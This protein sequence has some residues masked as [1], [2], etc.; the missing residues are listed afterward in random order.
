MRKNIAI[1]AVAVAAVL[2]VS[3]VAVYILTNSNNDKYANI[4]MVS[5]PVYG[6]A[7]EDYTINQADVDMINDLISDETKWE[8]HPY[9]D[10]DGDGK[11][12]SDDAEIVKKLINGESTKVRFIDQYFYETGNKHLVE[13]D[14]PLSNV[15]TIN[16]DMAQLTFVFDGGTVEEWNAIEKTD[17][18]NDGAAHFTVL[19][20]DGSVAY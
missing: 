12:T 1:I 6:N 13:V 5:L 10:A 9:A 20:D 16:P 2:V 18:W 17:G 15:V 4:K 3:G 14:Y 11:V 7:N 19:C 8:E